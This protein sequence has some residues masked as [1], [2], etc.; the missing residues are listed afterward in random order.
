M[1]KSFDFLFLLRFLIITF[2]YGLELAILRTN[3]FAINIPSFVLILGLYL[4]TIMISV[5]VTE[6]V[7]LRI[8]I[9]SDI[10]FICIFIIMLGIALVITIRGFGD[11]ILF[12]VTLLLIFP[13]LFFFY[14]WF[15]KDIK[16]IKN[17]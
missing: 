11:G 2:L 14:V 13:F 4:I 12:G 16:P 7:K 10:I 3:L 1:K 17:L 9:V 5:F 15:K 8:K 6:T